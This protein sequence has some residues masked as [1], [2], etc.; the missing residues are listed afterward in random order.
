MLVANII[1][2]FAYLT[3]E[4]FSNVFPDKMNTL[5]VQLIDGEDQM[6]HRSCSS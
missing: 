6:I 2:F 5:C 1:V 3:C 4:L